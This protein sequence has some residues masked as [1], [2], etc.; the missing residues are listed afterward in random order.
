VTAV[1]AAVEAVEAVEA[2][3][4]EQPAYVEPVAAPAQQP[5]HAGLFDAMPQPSAPAPMIEPVVAEPAIEPTPEALAE[6]DPAK[7]A[8]EA[9]EAE[10]HRD[11]S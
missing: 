5:S 3:E 8:D 7:A 1:P 2:I 4:P 11:A 10:A 6:T 9:A